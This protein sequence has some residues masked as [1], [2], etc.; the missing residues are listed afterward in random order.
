MARGLAGEESDLKMLPSFVTELPTGKEAGTVYALDLG[1]TNFRVLRVVLP[2]NGGEIKTEFRSYALQQSHM[3]GCGEADLFPFLASCIKETV[4]QLEGALPAA[5]SP[6]PLGFTFSF[7]TQQSALNQG[8]LISW[9]KGFCADKCVGSDVVAMLQKA[10]NALGVHVV[11]KALANDTVG[12]LMA[13]RAKETNTSLGVIFGT[14]T[15]GC[16]VE[17]MKKIGKWTGGEVSSGEQCINIE[18]G[19][20]GASASS[21]KLLPVTKHDDALDVESLN[22][23]EQILEK[24][25]GGMYMGELVRRVFNAAADAGEIM[26]GRSERIAAGGITTELSSNIEAADADGLVSILGQLGISAPAPSDADALQKIAVAISGRGARVSACAMAAIVQH[27][28]RV[29]TPTV[30]GID[31]SVFKCYTNFKARIEAC[32]REIFGDAAQHISLQ[33]SEDGSGIGAAVI[34][35]TA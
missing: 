20:F 5:D 21:R 24:M 2:G 15:N 7:P 25:I 32:M 1:G 13:L 10:L 26:S 4:E 16:Y 27:M 29:G 33:L 14:G 35:A 11:V 30:I 22:K 34:A 17:Q 31:G 6:L 23:G 19:N 28:E 12:T 8:T 9:T 18:W 3:T